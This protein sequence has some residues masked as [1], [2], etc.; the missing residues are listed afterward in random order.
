MSLADRKINGVVNKYYLT[1]EERVVNQKL[2]DGGLTKV[3]IRNDM[4]A[5]KLELAP[6]CIERIIMLKIIGHNH[7]INMS[8]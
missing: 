6:Y 4:H 5:L 3:H 2:L 7:N 8:S 1:P